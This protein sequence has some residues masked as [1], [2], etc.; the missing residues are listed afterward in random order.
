MLPVSHCETQKVDGIVFEVFKGGQLKGHA[1]CEV[2]EPVSMLN[3]QPVEGGLSDLRM[4]STSRDF[5]CTTCNM[6]HP[7]CPGHFGYIELAEPF[8][9]IGLFDV[10]LQALRCVCKSCG[11]LLQDPRKIANWDEIE[12]L[13]GRARL[14]AVVKL[15]GNRQKCGG[16]GGDEGELIDQMDGDVNL[17]RG[18]RQAQPKI[19]KPQGCYPKLVLEAT[20]PESNQTTRWIR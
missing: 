12:P 9:N 19:R 16:G 5:T 18:C 4:G 15:C 1:V 7:D 11:S 2:K 20:D 13:K 10:T 14:S 17:G 3:N 8:F 6:P